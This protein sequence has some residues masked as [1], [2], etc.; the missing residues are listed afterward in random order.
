MK[1]MGKLN[2]ITDP[3]RIRDNL[4][5]TGNILEILAKCLGIAQDV[6]RGWGRIPSALSGLTEF[7][8]YVCKGIVH[9]KCL[10]QQHKL[11]WSCPQES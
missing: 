4:E 9:T 6:G 7:F 8:S 10:E 2:T 11:L 1:E 5:K 3:R